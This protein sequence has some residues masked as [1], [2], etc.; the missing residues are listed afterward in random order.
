MGLKT[1]A[2]AHYVKFLRNIPLEVCGFFR[3]LSYTNNNVALSYA[4]CAYETTYAIPINAGN[5]EE[6][7]RIQRC[8]ILLEPTRIYYILNMK[9]T[10]LVS[11]YFLNDMNR[12]V[13]FWWKNW[14]IRKHIAVDFWKVSY[15]KPLVLIT[16]LFFYQ[17]STHNVFYY[18][19]Q[20]R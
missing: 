12:R 11:L 4:L 5:E 10:I 13:N 19:Y 8:W 14:E 18:V 7:N 17:E 15:L 16:C 3:Q 2:P 20:F 9:T 1:C 6:T